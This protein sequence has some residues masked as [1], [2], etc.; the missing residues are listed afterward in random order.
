MNSEPHEAAA[1]FRH[2]SRGNPAVEAYFR[3]YVSG[4]ARRLSGGIGPD[5]TEAVAFELMRTA[6]DETTKALGT[7]YRDGLAGEPLRAQGE[8]A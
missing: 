1:V 6:Q 2:S 3:G 7:G 4:I 5:E 8:S